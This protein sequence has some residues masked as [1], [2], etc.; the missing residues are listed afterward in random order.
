MCSFLSFVWCKLLDI[1]IGSKRIRCLQLLHRYIYT[2]SIDDPAYCDWNVPLK[3]FYRLQF[4][5]GFLLLAITKPVQ[6]GMHIAIISTSYPT[7]IFLMTHDIL[8]VINCMYMS[9]VCDLA[10][11]VSV[12]TMYVARS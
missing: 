10:W 5:N 3:T 12:Y 1:M 4:S 7:T 6:L 2:R 9:V 8:F 11:S